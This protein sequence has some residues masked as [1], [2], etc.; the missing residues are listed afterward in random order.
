MK[1]ISRKWNFQRFMLS[2][3]LLSL[4]VCNSVVLNRK[5]TAHPTMMPTSRPTTLPS[6]TDPKLISFSLDGSTGLITL[7]FNQ[8][9]NS[10]T[11]DITGISLIPRKS[12]YLTSNMTWT[13]IQLV[14]LYSLYST[15]QISQ[16]I[17]FFMSTMDYARVVFAN[18]EVTGSFNSIGLTIERGSIA[19]LNRTDNV[20]I[21]STF[22]LLISSYIA[23]I[24]KP[25][26]V[27][28][29]LNMNTGIL[30]LRFTEPIM[31]TTFT[32]YGIALQDQ[33]NAMFSTSYVTLVNE[34]SSIFNI[35]ESNTHISVLLGSINLNKIKEKHM[36]CTS[37]DTTYLSTYLSFVNDTSNNP[38]SLVALDRSVGLQTSYFTNDITSPTLIEWNLDLNNGFMEIIFSETID[39]NYLNY[40]AIKLAN[41][42]N[43]SANNYKIETISIPNSFVSYVYL[44]EMNSNYHSNNS[45]TVYIQFDSL[46][47]NNIKYNKLICYQKTNCFLI[48][49]S[50]VISDTSIP[51]NYYLGTDATIHNPRLVHTYVSDTTKPRLLGFLIDLSKQ[52]IQLNFTKIMNVN[53]IHLQALTLQSASDVIIGTEIIHLSQAKCSVITKNDSKII[54]IYLFKETY[55]YLIQLLK[56]SKYYQ[57]TYISFDSSFISDNVYQSNSIE[58]ISYYLAMQSI[59]IISDTIKPFLLSWT[60]NIN[61]NNNENT[62]KMIFSKPINITNININTIQ[63]TN[64]KELNYLSEFMYFSTNNSYI[65]NQIMNI[66]TIKLT[67]LFINQL[68][69]YNLLCKLQ[70][71]CYLSFNDNF[72]YNI[73]SFDENNEF[74][75]TKIEKT[76]F[77]MISNAINDTIK[78]KINDFSV[79][80][81]KLL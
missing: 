38:I 55:Y 65:F 57:T 60:L 46:F 33:S 7:N 76:E 29:E 24:R 70:Y 36:L 4:I 16:S 19:S 43:N 32:L 44:S 58:E 25:Y 64:Q 71:N 53:S 2:F 23:D 78:P 45:N 79:N 22:P 72:G 42:V 67:N 56:L 5:P 14:E 34:N 62:I 21:N 15:V 26:L 9:M 1:T 74:I 28:F 77:L 35:T 48:L 11:L 68:N 59:K 41:I 52:I 27:S 80:L 40:S 20:A 75:Q 39:L 69:S 49:E 73:G 54:E 50:N 6:I 31:I 51:K 13:K 8:N 12:N 37:I 3:I 10:S 63:L 17:S 61:E 47:L 30:S 18:S 81:T 66:V